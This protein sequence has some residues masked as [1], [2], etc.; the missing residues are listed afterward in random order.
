MAISNPGRLSNP[1]GQDPSEIALFK[2][3]K[4]PQN[5]RKSDRFE[6]LHDF[7]FDCCTKLQRDSDG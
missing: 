6:V 1:W 4:F 2:G 7:S 3:Y 5:P